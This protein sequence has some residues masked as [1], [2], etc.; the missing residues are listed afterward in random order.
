M[1]TPHFVRKTKLDDLE[2]VRAQGH[3]VVEG[4]SAL[5]GG[6]LDRYGRDAANLF[7]EPVVTQGNNAAPTT[8]SWYAAEDGEPQRLTALEGPARAAGEADLKRRLSAVEP[9]LSDPEIGS[10][11]R[12][13]LYVSSPDDILLINGQTVLTNWGMAPR[14][15]L[16]DPLDRQRHFESTLGPYAPFGAPALGDVGTP[17]PALGAAGGMAA[18]AAVAGAGPAPSGGARAAGPGPYPAAPAAAG[19]GAGAAGAAGLAAGAA[20]AAGAATA[21]RAGGRPWLPVLIATVVAAIVLLALLLPGVLLYPPTPVADEEPD[22][23]AL[24]ALQRET[25]RSLEEQIRAAE[26]MLEQGI[27][28]VEDSTLILP[29]QSGAPALPIRPG[30]PTIADPGAAPGTPGGGAVTPDSLLPLE[31]EATLVPPAARPVQEPFDGSLVDLLDATTAL[32][33]A[34]KPEQLGIG[35]GFFVAPGLLVTSLHVVDGAVPERVF[36]T[37]RTLGRLQQVDV[38]HRTEAV[39]IGE[40][41]FAILRVSGAEHL[42]RLALT[43]AVGRLDNVVAAGYPTIVLD[44]DLNFQALMNG[45]INA[46]PE[47]ALTQGVVTVI[48]NLNQSLPVIAHTAAIS[49]GNSGGPLVDGCGRVVGVNTF[50]R[51]DQRRATRMSYAI[52]SAGL[53]RFL[54]EKGIAYTTVDGPCRPSVASAPAGVAPGPAMVAPATPAA[55]DAAAGAEEGSAVEPA[56]RPSGQVDDAKPAA[57]PGAGSS[58]P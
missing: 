45:D 42:P 24:I 23:D 38:V 30:Q 58:S 5:Y 53:M 37:N 20:G 54:D 34:L 55:I 26:L 7:A 29:G 18:A 35:S 27:C 33:I 36:V 9:A 51:V 25:N 13:A 8:I 48:Q 22:L 32:V 1:A 56:E 39:A 3:W 40:P 16:D 46:I 49:P 2:T 14:G 52:V 6:L 31:P 4:Y 12:A 11:V 50:L 41:D 15:A 10:S 44:S 43:D 19:A 28:R 47:M 21:E 57:A 17:H